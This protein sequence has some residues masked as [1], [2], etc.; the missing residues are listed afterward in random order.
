MLHGAG[1]PLLT[2]VSPDALVLPELHLAQ[3][4]V[5]V[6]GGK[7]RKQLRASG[8]QAGEAVLESRIR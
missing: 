2:K 8:F 6:L 5:P 3:G 7:M 1:F 4:P